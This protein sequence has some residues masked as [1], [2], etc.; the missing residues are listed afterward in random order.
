MSRGDFTRPVGRK[1][2]RGA[3]ANGACAAAIVAALGIHSILADE[4]FPQPN[5]PALVAPSQDVM[6]E[7][8]SEAVPAPL[9]IPTATNSI[10]PP[11]ATETPA[12]APQITA[13]PPPAPVPE[14]PQATAEIKPPPPP[15]PP[16]PAQI[17]GLTGK[18]RAR[19]EKCLANAIY[20]EARGEL[21]RG[22]VAVAQVVMNRVFSPYYPKDVCSVVYQNAHQHLACQF[23]FACDGKSKAI[24]EKGAWWRA[25]RIARKTLDGKV[26]VAAVAKSTH[27]HAYWV[28]PSWVGEMKKMFKYGVHTFYRPHRW[29]D[30][31]QE[32]GWVQPAMAN[33]QPEVKPQPTST[34]VK[35]AAS[36]ATKPLPTNAQAK[37]STTD[38]NAKTI[39]A[40]TQAKASTADNKAKALPANAQAKAPPASSPTKPSQKVSTQ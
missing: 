23:T 25:Q 35:P 31:S 14:A 22:Q 16:T 30:G 21:L 34:P 40:N 17:L 38:A 28:K 15:P 4:I 8:S 33:S 18:E 9:E 5:E 32:A 24:T 20:F 10:P 6:A 7:Q 26:W 29:G 37:G 2:I 11:A 27:Y 13:V 1:I 39:P 19:H 12:A 3:I 36:N